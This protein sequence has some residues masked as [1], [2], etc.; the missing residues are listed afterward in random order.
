MIDHK[1]AQLDLDRRSRESVPS[2]RARLSGN[3]I[4]LSGRLSVDRTPLSAVTVR[5]SWLRP[6]SL[7]LAA[8]QAGRWPLL[9]TANQCRRSLFLE[10]VRLTHFFA[11]N[12]ATAPSSLQEELTWLR[13]LGVRQVILPLEQDASEAQQVKA[14]GAIQKL[15]SENCR[16]AA[17]LR[18]KPGVLAEPDT[19]HQFCH[20]ILSQVGWQ[21]ESAQLGEGVDGLVREH[22]DIAA[23][24]QLFTHVPRLRRDYPGVALRAPGMERFEAVLSVQALL[25]LLPE[26][27]VWDSLSVRAPAWQVL[28]SVGR[29]GIF[30]RR[31]TLAGA[32]AMQPG[33]VSGKVQVCF[34]APPAGCD[35]PAEERMA[36]SVV[37]R[38]VLALCSGVANQ[39]AI[40]MDP[41]L[42]VAERKVL[43]TAIR[44]LVRLLEGA[45]FERRLW[46]G[47]P[48]RDYVLEFSR[49][50]KSSVLLGWTDGEPQLI[51]VPLTI[52]AARDFLCRPVPMIPYPRIRLTRNMAYFEGA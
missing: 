47:D 23:G 25:R 49:S 26:G 17:V 24:A 10:P 7:A 9:R 46:V 1:G 52:G 27:H 30:L 37:R 2:R 29:D 31:L 45:R 28:E 32:V 3:W 15:S 39:V 20:W 22:K 42:Q 51:A 6:L 33:V 35:G 16:V 21:L 34:P 12:Y 36:G 14:L 40:G 5:R 50:G 11:I 48:N 8:F 13:E 38:A 18:P 41:G 4:A 43:S 19:W 44:E